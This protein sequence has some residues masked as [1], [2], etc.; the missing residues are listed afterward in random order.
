M[1]TLRIGPP[2]TVKAAIFKAGIKG[3]DEILFVEFTDGTCGT[4]RNGRE[5]G[6]RMPADRL[7]EG[8]ETFLDLCRGCVSNVQRAG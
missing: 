2:A 7:E 1:K 4:L 8:L 3:I 5:I 6:P